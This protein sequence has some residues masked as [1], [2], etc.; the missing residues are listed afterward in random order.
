MHG[1]L[2]ERNT[3]FFVKKNKNLEIVF[4]SQFISKIHLMSFNKRNK[5]IM[6]YNL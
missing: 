1:Y 2:T 4:C 3:F 5:F 6:E